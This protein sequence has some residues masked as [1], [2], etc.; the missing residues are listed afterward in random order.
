MSGKPD[1]EQGLPAVF[2]LKY[3]VG[4]YGSEDMDKS[5][6]HAIKGSLPIQ[7]LH[8]F[9]AQKKNTRRPWPTGITKNKS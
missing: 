8:D 1:S 6:Y 9:L 7:Y 5:F 3:L 4:F 2:H